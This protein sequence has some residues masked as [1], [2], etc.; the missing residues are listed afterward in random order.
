[1]EQL[2]RRLLF[3]AF[4]VLLTSGCSVLSLKNQPQNGSDLNVPG[5]AGGSAKASHND[6]FSTGPGGIEKTFYNSYVAQCKQQMPS[7]NTMPV[8]G[9]PKNPDE[10]CNCVATKMWDIHRQGKGN[11]DQ[12]AAQKEMMACMGVNMDELKNKAEE[13]RRRAEA[14]AEGENFVPPEIQQEPAED[15]PGQW[16]HL[17]DEEKPESPPQPE[18][19]RNVKFDPKTGTW[20]NN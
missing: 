8:G 3:F 2:M 12:V 10:V 11:V 5:K 15:V 7:M 1:M 14:M 4:L 6:I 16:E 17:D 13:Q 18:A 20:T 9:T 19:K